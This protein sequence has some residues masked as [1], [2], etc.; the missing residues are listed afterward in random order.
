MQI[1][2]IVSIEA[3]PKCSYRYHILKMYTKKSVSQLRLCCIKC[4]IC[5]QNKT[6]NVSAVS[7]ACFVTWKSKR[8]QNQLSHSPSILHYVLMKNEKARMSIRG[9]YSKDKFWRKITMDCSWRMWLNWICFIISFHLIHFFHFK[10][11]KF[12]PM[13]TAKCKYFCIYMREEKKEKNKHPV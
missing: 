13:Q 3:I 11:W 2:G 9:V 6:K 1:W 4:S 7:P 10:T 8:K 12:S 5:L